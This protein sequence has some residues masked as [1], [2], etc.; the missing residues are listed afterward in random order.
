MKTKGLFF[1]RVDLHIHTPASECFLDNKITPEQIV[2]KSIEMGLSAIAITDHNTGEWIDKVK[3]AA[4][5]TNLTIFPG[6]EITVGDAHNHI[7]AIL[8]KDKTTRDIED[9]LTTL[10]ILHNKYGEKEAFSLKP[11]VEVIEIITGDKFNGI[12]IPAHIDSTNGV[13]EQ[14]KKSGQARKEV[15]Q[16]PK[17]LAVEA[18]N[19]QKVSKL[20]DG[21]D[22]IYQ[23]KLTV[24]Q[25]SDNP[26]LDG[27]GNIIV[28]GTYAGKH[29]MDGIGFRFSYFKVDDN[30]FLE[31][32]RQCFIDPEV[33][34][35][36]SFEYKERSYPYT[37]SVKINSGFLIDVESTFH[38]GL[39]SILGAKGVGKSLLIEFMRFA[40]DQESAHP[41]ISNDHEEKLSKQLGQY[42][43]VK[44]NICDETGKEFQISRTY[45]PAE[46]NPLHCR[47]LS[48]NEVIDVNIAQLFPA[49]FLSQT[50]II[51][52][53]EDPNEQMK[54]IDKF[55][56]F[57][58]YRNQIISLESEL[59]ELDRIFAEALRAY[60][61]ERSFNKQLQTAKVEMERLSTQLKNP[62]FDE[63]AK[64]EE[65]DKAFRVQQTFLKALVDHIDNFER[66]IKSE[67]PPEIPKVLS[68]DPALRR[69]QDSIK[70]VMSLLLDG[71]ITQRQNLNETIQK[72]SNEYKSWKTTFDEKK[73]K[74]QE[75]VLK[76]GGDSQKLEE[77]RK[78]KAK[79]IENFE[80]KLHFIGNKTKQIKEIS[81][82]RNEKLEELKKVYTDYLQARKERCEYFEKVSNGKLQVTIVESTNKDEFQ[83]SL[84]SLKRGSYLREGEIEQLCDKITPHEFILNLLRYDIS[85]TEQVEDTGKYTKEIAK[86]TDLPEEKVKNLADHLLNTKSYEEL[87]HLQYKAIRQD[88][89][90][91]KY[92]IGDN[93]KAN[94]VLLKN[95]STGQKCTAMVILALSE[96]IMPIIIDQPED[97][98]DI[99]AIWDDMCSKLRT[100]KEFRQF[101]FTTHNSS[102]AVASDTDKFMI[103]TA[104]ATKGEIVFS[105]AID[106]EEVREEVIKYL[107]GGLTTYRLKY[108][109]YDIPKKLKK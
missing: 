9:L 23:R 108:L 101:I 104:S 85:R 79:E 36:Q 92:N 1:R 99:R 76:L 98:L 7:I 55:F 20:L 3:T 29:S 19:Y 63:F 33:R 24:Y 72:I 34:V 67:D 35:R 10:G 37:K 56:D 77:K 60:H 39:N 21:N 17:L 16:H 12:A 32:L 54:F 91:I 66:I 2:K 31:S 14:M 22:P 5:G 95:L 75:Q 15:I 73:T 70:N 82:M 41:E 11:V 57:H 74:F 53:A 93:K 105:G 30:I 46:D 80:K 87:L 44:I 89:P 97:S 49:L 65:K 90:E 47:D 38:H 86:L 68:S 83:R 78:I 100:G 59:E 51:K 109:K 94:F 84:I 61:E 102:V 62:I 103:M 50:E 52:I 40:L 106:N 107:E 18:V 45:N 27:D 58:R 43:Q 88:R 4:H 28:S 64:L 81:K 6:V 13:F 69:S 96:G 71:F 48:N 25:S 8:D 42:G 26:Y